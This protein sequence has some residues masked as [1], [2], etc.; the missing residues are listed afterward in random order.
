M[1]AEEINER[2]HRAKRSKIRVYPVRN[3][4]A[5]NLGHPCERY[6]YLLL[7]KWDEQKPHDEGLQWIFDL[8]NAMEAYTIEN[9]KEAGYEVVTPTVRSWKVD[10]PLITG[11]EDVRIKDEK[12]NLLPVEIK[13]LNPVEW[14]RLDSVEDFFKSKRAH[15]RGYP[16]QLQVY[17]YHFGKDHG[18]FALTNKLTGET[19]MIDVPFDYE[20][21]N[22]LFEKARRIYKDIET[23]TLPDSTDDPSV[24]EC[25]PLRHVCASPA[26]AQADVDDTGDLE[27]LIN[28][29]Q[30]LAEA[31]REYEEVDRE[32]KAMVGE[33]ERIVTSS[34]LV[35]RTKV[36]RKE[37]LVK[38]RTD[39]QVRIK[40]L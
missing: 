4:R 16:A 21:A 7:T 32:I 23:G 3:L 33:R 11:R 15:V 25:C 19:K 5:S 6:L 14:A 38:A 39:W 10:E 13:G 2:L 30:A 12:G 20:Y 1:T 40:R 17:L 28:R 36:E 35:T 37:Y 8:G 31:R 22:S 24:C 18:F 9:L 27:E 34:W 26:V 29:K